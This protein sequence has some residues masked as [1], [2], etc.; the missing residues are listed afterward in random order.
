MNTTQE[1]KLSMYIAVRDYLAKFLTILNVLPKFKELYAALQNA[2]IEIQHWSGLQG[3]DKSGNTTGKNSLKE[4][5]I[6]LG[7]DTA[8]KLVAF[9]TFT[10]NALLLSKV[11]VTEN[12]LKKMSDILLINTMQGIY[13]LAQEHVDSLLTYKVTP[14]T[15][16]AFLNA[17]TDFKES[18]SK[19]RVGKSETGQAT[20]EL[21]IQYEKADGIIDDLVTAIDIIRSEEPTFFIGFRLV[22]KV[23][24]RGTT[25]IALKGKITDKDTGIGLRGVKVTFVS[26]SASLLANTSNGTKKIEKKTAEKGGFMVKNMADGTYTV[27]IELTGYKKKAVT[28]Y[29]VSGQ[30]SVLNEVLERA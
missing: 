21:I 2:I 23:I 14:A 28:I 20:Q 1:S 27:T 3:F 6:A 13:D 22:R 16:T 9:A 10:N 17:L 24:I 19:P 7:A 11:K 25:T 8:R 29:V 15:Q 18:M 12:E 5:L 30:M 4:T 26:E